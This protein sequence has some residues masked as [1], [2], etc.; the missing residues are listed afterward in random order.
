V[1]TGGDRTAVEAVLADRRLSALVVVPPKLSV[2]D[3]RRSVLEQ[4]VVDA[5]SVRMRVTN[6]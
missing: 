5:C 3:P 6:A 4:A 2:P 1:V